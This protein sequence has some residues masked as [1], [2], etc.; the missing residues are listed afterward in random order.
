[1]RPACALVVVNSVGIAIWRISI[2]RHLPGRIAALIAVLGGLAAP[3]AHA[4]GT[5]VVGGSLGASVYKSG[6]DNIFVKFVG[7]QARYVNDLY[8]Y[9]T[10]PGAGQFLLRNTTAEGTVVEATTSSALAIGAEAI[11]S[12]CANLG[13]APAGTGCTSAPADV[14]GNQYYSG[15]AS[16]NPDNRFHDMVWTRE[17]Y[18]AGCALSPTNCSPNI[19][20][21]LTD[22][23]YNI[24]VGF[25]D[26]YN[27]NIDNDFNDIVF[28][29][30]GT[31]LTPEPMTIALMATGLSGVAGAGVL[32]QRRP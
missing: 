1:M 8:Y 15:P 24:V 30:R 4:D 27:Y 29:V 13:A 10:L 5:A 28:A 14:S 2:N 9:L 23:S 32:R 16:R 3:A 26:S 22:P 12:I 6:T 11:F 18:L 7:K 17:A 20:T 25:E 21:L 31:T 19:A